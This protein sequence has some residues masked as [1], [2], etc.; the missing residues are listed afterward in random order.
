MKR[1]VLNLLIL[2]GVLCLIGQTVQAEEEKSPEGPAGQKDA[3]L[4]VGS[5][6]IHR[7]KT[8]TEDFPGVKVINKGVDG[9]QIPDCTRDVERV[10][11]PLAPRLIIFYAGD[12]DL[13][14]HKTPQQVAEDYQKFVKHLREFLPSTPIGFISIKPSP[15]RAAL[16]TQAKEANELIKNYIA[17]D[18]SQFYIDVFADM[19]GAD[20]QPR[21]ELFGP[22]KLHMNAEGYRLWQAAVAPHLK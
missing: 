6:S 11:A 22:D 5:S 12:N 14:A 20:G 13:G 7:W 10:M 4:F 9:Y 8:L 17:Q 16:L 3:V 21:A 2:L 1:D 15:A 19:L 18:P